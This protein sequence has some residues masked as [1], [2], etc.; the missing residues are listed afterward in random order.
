VTTTTEHIYNQSAKNSNYKKRIL[1]VDDDEPDIAPS[2]KIGL[3]C[4]EDDKFKV[5][6]FNDPIEVLSNYKTGHCDLL[7]LDVKIPNINGCNYIEK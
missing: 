7:L 1:I 4:D 2:L 6:T 5:N 3:E